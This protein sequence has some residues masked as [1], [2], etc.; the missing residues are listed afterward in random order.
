MAIF[1]LSQI[2]VWARAEIWLVTAYFL[3]GSPSLEWLWSPLES[4]CSS[5]SS[6]LN[7][8]NF[9]FQFY[10]PVVAV[11]EKHRDCLNIYIT[12]QVFIWTTRSLVALS[13]KFT[14]VI[15][16]TDAPGSHWLCSVCFSKENWKASP[17]QCGFVAAAF[18]GQVGCYCLCWICVF[19]FHPRREFCGRFCS[20]LRGDGEVWPFPCLPQC[21]N[22]WILEV[23]CTSQTSVYGRDPHPSVSGSARGGWGIQGEGEGLCVHTSHEHTHRVSQRSQWGTHT[24]G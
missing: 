17:C 21:T 3:T 4:F 5:I 14:S 22:P 11:Q 8:P 23:F 10:L 19:S 15:I 7:F 24:K 12:L 1:T 9:C 16:F 6:E 20:S 2:I 18:Q 13:H